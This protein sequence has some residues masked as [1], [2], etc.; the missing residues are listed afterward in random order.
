MIVVSKRFIR[1]K[2]RMLFDAVVN[3]FLMF[4]FWVII[5]ADSIFEIHV[6]FLFYPE[7]RL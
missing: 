4:A 2:S 7:N 6:V 5:S 1:K 3:I